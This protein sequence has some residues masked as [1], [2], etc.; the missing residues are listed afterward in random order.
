MS[1]VDAVAL[2][3]RGRRGGGVVG[4]IVRLRVV[5]C[6]A[7]GCVAL[8]LWLAGAGQA[9]ASGWAIQAVPVLP[10]PTGSSGQ[11]S[12]VSCASRSSCTAVGIYT[13]SAGVT[14]PLAERWTGVRWRIQQ[15]PLPAGEQ[16]A[17]LLGVACTSEIACTA[18]GSS[19]GPGDVT[20]TLAERWN[21]SRWTVQRTSN[22]VRGSSPSL[23]GVSCTSRTACIAVGAAGLAERWNG[24]RWMIRRAASPAGATN[25]SLSG[26]WCVSSGD[27]T[28]VGTYT[29]RAGTQVALAESFDGTRWR[30]HNAPTAAGAKSTAL[31][32]VSCTS[33]NACTT[34]GSLTSSALASS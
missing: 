34:V 32:G 8:A 23:S 1:R 11:L 12:A 30:I 28:A 20:A 6:A 16:G 29:D 33:R 13:D 27:C 5:A 21:G 4:V 14:L 19:T 9:V 24:K 18:V 10:G 17:T 25:I 26:V 15:M 22:P 3:W 31:V 2:W 7:V